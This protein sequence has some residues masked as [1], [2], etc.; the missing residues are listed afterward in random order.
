MIP[1][2]VEALLI[3]S[4]KCTHR[5]EYSKPLASNFDSSAITAL[6]VCQPSVLVLCVSRAML[7]LT[8]G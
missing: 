4:R 5:Y 1:L 6:I 7:M 8:P 2:V 3:F